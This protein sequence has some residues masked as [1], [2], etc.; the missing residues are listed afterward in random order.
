LGA[1]HDIR[2]PR[3]TVAIPNGV[4]IAWPG[5]WT[6]GTTYTPAAAAAGGVG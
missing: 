2:R 4:A 1:W 5:L 3:D 6:L